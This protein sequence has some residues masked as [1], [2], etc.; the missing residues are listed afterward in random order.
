VREME[1]RRKPTAG[2]CHALRLLTSTGC[3]RRRTLTGYHTI[4]YDVRYAAGNWVDQ[5]V[6]RDKNWVTSGQP[7]DIPAERLGER[8]THG[9]LKA[10]PKTG[11]SRLVRLSALGVT[12]CRYSCNFTADAMSTK[13]H[14]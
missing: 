4:Q 9:C 11:N 14:T 3:V 10:C 12:V 1:R 6:V 2:I 5:E 8:N 13:L 7:S